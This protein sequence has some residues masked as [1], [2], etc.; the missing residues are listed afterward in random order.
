VVLL[1]IIEVRRTDKIGEGTEVVKLKSYEI[2]LVVV[3]VER[4][5]SMFGEDK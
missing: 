2:A 4:E 5:K 1:R 3:V